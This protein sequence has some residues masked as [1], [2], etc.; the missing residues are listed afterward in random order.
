VTTTAT[1]PT[2][3]VHCQAQHPDPRKRGR[4]CGAVLGDIPAGWRFVGLSPTRPPQNGKTQLQC[5]RRDC[6]TWNLF[7]KPHE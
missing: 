4:R 7:E 1:E 6:R 3:R 2:T 5:G